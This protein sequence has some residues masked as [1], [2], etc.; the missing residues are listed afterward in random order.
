MFDRVNSKERW[1]RV[2]WMKTFRSDFNLDNISDHVPSNM[3]L[4]EKK[5]MEREQ[6]DTDLRIAYVANIN[7]IQLRR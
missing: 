6:T 5:K 3:Q 7:G 1:K 4:K 2:E